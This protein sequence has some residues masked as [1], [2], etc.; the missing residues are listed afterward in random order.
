[1]KENSAVKAYKR[2]EFLLLF[3]EGGETAFLSDAGEIIPVNNLDDTL[4]GMTLEEK[5]NYLKKQMDEYDEAID[6]IQCLIEYQQDA[7]NA[8]EVANLRRDL[9]RDQV[10]KRY[11]I[12][13][14][15]ELK[16]A[17]VTTNVVRK[18]IAVAA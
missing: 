14:Y 5:I 6:E 1:M 4:T 7:N 16:E 15:K 17:V 10:E 12:E 9:K 11:L 8:E 13:K 3:S 2:N 18:D